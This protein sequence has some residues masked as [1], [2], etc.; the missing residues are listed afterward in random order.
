MQKS[1][2][3][4]GECNFPWDYSSFGQSIVHTLNGCFVGYVNKFTTGLGSFECLLVG[5]FVSP[6]KGLFDCTLTKD[7]KEK[8]VLPKR[9]PIV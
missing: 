8:P 7:G 3:R 6:K 1:E 9:V 2:H 4:V 5:I